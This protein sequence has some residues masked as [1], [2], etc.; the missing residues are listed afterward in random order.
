[1]KGNG[2]VPVEIKNTEG[3]ADE[4][5]MSDAVVHSGELAEGDREEQKSVEDCAGLMKG[6]VDTED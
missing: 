4:V 1:M 5:A 6:G 2:D 3:V